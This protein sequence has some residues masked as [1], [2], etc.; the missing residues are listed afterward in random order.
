M[1]IR[2]PSVFKMDRG[3]NI[4]ILP[5]REPQ[6]YLVPQKTSGPYEAAWDSLW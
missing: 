5:H 3:R 1:T 4:I 6:N 2:E